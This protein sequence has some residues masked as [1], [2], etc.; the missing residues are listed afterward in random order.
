MFVAAA[1][2]LW[3]LVPGVGAQGGDLQASLE[4]GLRPDGLGL[5]I[6]VS[7]Q[8]SKAS[9]PREEARKVR[10]EINV[11]RNAWRV[12][13]GTE[14]AL[15]T[16]LSQLAQ[17]LVDSQCVRFGQFKLKSGIMSPIYLDLRRL[18]THPQILKR[19]AQ[20]YAETLKELSFDRL[21]GIPMRRC[22]L[23]RLS[24]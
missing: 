21:A 1:P 16:T 18:V 24:R 3:F 10:D 14:H 23:R 6:N 19:V 20:A 22:R 7:R 11:V 9:D 8:I 15:R 17:D 2:D 13:P 5:L 12:K 4:A